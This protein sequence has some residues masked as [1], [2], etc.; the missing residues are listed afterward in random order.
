MKDFCILGSGIAGSTIANLLSERYT[1]EVF[2]KGRNAGG[3]S[4]HRKFK[5][6]LSFDHG[7]QYFSSEN[8]KFNKFLNNLKKK[9]S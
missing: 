6:D 5:K 7:V 3:R 2:D 9:K 8:I 1:V 4:A